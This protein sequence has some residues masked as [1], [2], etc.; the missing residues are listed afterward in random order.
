[1]E[2]EEWEKCVLKLGGGGEKVAM[3]EGRVE[4]GEKRR[5]GERKQEQ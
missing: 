1:M 5:S 2:R 4:R 3:R